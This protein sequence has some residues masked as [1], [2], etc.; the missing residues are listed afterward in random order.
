VHVVLWF[1]SLGDGGRVVD[2]ELMG[3]RVGCRI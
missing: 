2:G 1:G 3:D